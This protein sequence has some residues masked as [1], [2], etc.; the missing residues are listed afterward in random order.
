MNWPLLHEHIVSVDHSRADR[1]AIVWSSGLLTHRELR[2][3]VLGIAARLRRLGIGRN[4]RAAICLPKCVEAVQAVL[5]TLAS[6][7][8]YVPVDASAPASRIHHIIS[9]AQ[10]SLL[11][12]TESIHEKLVAEG[13]DKNLPP[14]TVVRELGTGH[15]LDHWLAN[16]SSEDI[17]LGSLDDTAT[18]LYTSGSTGLP[19]GVMLSHRNVSSFVQWAIER[20]GLSADDRFTSHAPFHFDLSTL[21][22]F[23]SLRVGASVFLIDEKMVRFPA[24]VAKVLEQQRISVWYSVPTALR[25]LR[26]YGGLGRRDLSSLR[27]VFFAGEVFPVPSLRR[28]M[29]QLSHPRYVNLYGPTETNV[30]TYHV[31]D[32]TPGEDET[33]VPIGIPC[34]HLGV[35]IRGEIE[36]P[37]PSGEVGEICVTGPGVM[38][39]YWRQSDVTR[40]V[41]FDGRDDSYRTGD[42]GYW[43]DGTIQLAGRRDQQ[44]KIRGH[45]VEL[46][47][48]E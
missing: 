2:N 12:T 17:Q 26:E 9:D 34:E 3:S 8:T 42:F 16:I 41:R 18:I 25:L 20:F 45:R 38:Q 40:A 23:A 10:V 46:L 27:L 39:G 6:G 13:A 33:A 30:C 19:K 5:G 31:L 48:I 4:Q 15:G 7:A 35:T 21:D 36:K 47:E 43:S 32:G 11:F 28:L 44:I 22:L 24:A 37:I 29:Q 14:V 1:P